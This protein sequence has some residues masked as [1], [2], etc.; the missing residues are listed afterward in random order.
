M[1]ASNGSRLILGRSAELCNLVINDDTVSRQH[2]EIRKEGAVFLV[3]DRNSSNGTAVNGLF[4][5]NPFQAV[6]FKP[7]DTLTLGAVKLDFSKS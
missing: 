6:S 4:N 7:G 1:F 5:R 3:A 2:A